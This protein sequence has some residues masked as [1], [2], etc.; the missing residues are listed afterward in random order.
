MEFVWVFIVLAGWGNDLPPNPVT[1]TAPTEMGCIEARH[2]VEVILT[3]T[4][5]NDKT[6]KFWWI[7]SDCTEQP[8]ED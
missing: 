5:D 6:G 1:I 4:G 2:S 8:L 7:V 3:E